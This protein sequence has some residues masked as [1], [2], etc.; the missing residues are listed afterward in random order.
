MVWKPQDGRSNDLNHPEPPK[1]LD[2]VIPIQGCVA[3]RA[4]VLG[5]PLSRAVFAVAGMPDAGVE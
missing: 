4:P 5:T 2:F 3:R 1:A